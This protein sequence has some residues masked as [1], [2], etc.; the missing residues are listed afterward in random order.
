MLT[1]EHIHE[2][3][4]SESDVTSALAVAPEDLMLH[5]YASCFRENRAFPIKFR[6]RVRHISG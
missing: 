4:P 3:E 5:T 1:H 6:L 2:Y